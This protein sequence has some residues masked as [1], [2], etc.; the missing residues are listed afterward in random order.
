MESVPYAQ[1]RSKGGSMREPWFLQASMRRFAS[2]SFKSLT[3]NCL[4]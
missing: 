1:L 4:S 2:Q 3:E